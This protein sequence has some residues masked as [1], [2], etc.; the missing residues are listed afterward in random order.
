MWDA[1]FGTTPDRG[2]GQDLAVP[3]GPEGD[4]SPPPVRWGWEIKLRTQTDSRE[5]KRDKQRHTL[6]C[7]AHKKRY[8][9]SAEAAAEP[10]KSWAG[11]GALWEWGREGA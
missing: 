7:T 3:W 1:S 6:D 2:G 8:V 10:S 5:E 11:R 4:P 9:I